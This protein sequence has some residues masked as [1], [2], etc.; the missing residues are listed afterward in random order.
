MEVMTISIIEELYYDNVS[1][2]NAFLVKNKDLKKRMQVLTESK[3]YLF[4]NFRDEN[5]VNFKR[6]SAAWSFVDAETNREYFAY[7]FRLGAL[8]MQNVLM[9]KITD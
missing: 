2:Q 5:L 6:F 3:N 7:G 9:N 1:V 4:D 8:I